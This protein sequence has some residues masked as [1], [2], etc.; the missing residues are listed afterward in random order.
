[1]KKIISLLLLLA[2]ALSLLAFV[3]CEKETGADA[4]TPQVSENTGDT[5]NTE[6]TENT[7]TPN[8]SENKEIPA[9]GLWATA[10]YRQDKSFGEGEKTVY[11]EVKA[12]D[13]SVTFTIKT[14]ASTLSEA[15]LAHG[16]IQGN[17][18]LYTVVNGIAAVWSVDKSYWGFYKS[19]AYMMEGMDTTVIAD[20]EHYE[21]V[22]TK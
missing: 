8:D 6:N 15:L 11:V 7:E 20:G 9:E 21:L 18:G 17:D 19:G 16:L 12:N 1:M 2:L 14:N 5:E 3:G 22:Y 10:T 13:A 4:E